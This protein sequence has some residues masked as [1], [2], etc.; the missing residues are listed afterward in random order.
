[1]QKKRKKYQKTDKEKRV[2]V[3]KIKKEKKEK[4]KESVKK[5]L[6]GIFSSEENCDAEKAE[7]ISNEIVDEIFNQFRDDRNLLNDKIKSIIW[8]I[9]DVNNKE[10]RTSIVNHTLTAS[11]LCSMKDEDLASNKNEIKAMRES[12]KEEVVEKTEST[13]KKGKKK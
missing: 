5:L 6:K 4:E 10:L 13:I 3:N 9:K 2:P 11:E 1:M 12:V 8:H 7:K